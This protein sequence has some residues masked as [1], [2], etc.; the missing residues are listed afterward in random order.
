[1]WTQ[2][3]GKVR[4]ALSPHIN[5]W[6]QVPLYVTPRGLTTSAIPHGDSAFEIEFDFLTHNL[7][8]RGSN[9]SAKAVPLY[10]R[11]VADFYR[12]FRAVLDAMGIQARIWPMPVE[13]SY[14]IPFPEDQEHAAYDPRYVEAFHRCLLSVDK[15]LKKF[16]G[17][18]LGK[19]SPVHFFWGSFDLAVTRFSGRVAPPREGADKI[20]RE[21]YSHECS[22]AGFWPGI[23]GMSDAVLYSYSA[24]EPA[25]FA[26][27]KVRPAA[28]RYDHTLREFLMMYEEVRQSPDP[29]GMILEFCES[30]YEAGANLGKWDRSALE[31]RQESL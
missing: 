31:R 5:H 26:Q 7:E 6:W 8:L 14:P 23:A 1:M 25:G 9:G 13:V 19:A 21:A 15:V 28:A 4:L 3:V 22:S 27:A 17:G 16:R 10:A 29:A 30:T 20:T 2:I 12:E 11:S 18:F 24:P